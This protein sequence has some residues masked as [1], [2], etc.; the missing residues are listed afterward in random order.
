[1]RRAA[2]LI[3]ALLLSAC[4]GTAPP[5]PPPPPPPDPHTQMAALE[6]RI[7]VLIVE[8]RAKIDPDARPLAIDPE[9]GDIARKR[10]SDMADKNY[11]A[12]AAP[13]GDTSATL[14]MAEDAKFQGL[15]G[16]NLGALHYTKALGVDVPKFARGFV[17]QWLASPQ[18]RDNLAFKDYDMAGVGAAVNGDTVYVTALFATHLG[19]PPHEE[20]KTP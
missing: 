10:A 7:A 9:L 12:H 2:V 6:T 17:D 8:E 5:A 15:L 1:M 3:V 16:E 4:A 14:L 13:N 20:E 19:L 18:H 11:Y